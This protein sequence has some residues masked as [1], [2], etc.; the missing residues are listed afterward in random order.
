M[1]TKK[2]TVI[3]GCLW[4]LLSA[5]N[6]VGRQ[7]NEAISGEVSQIAKVIEKASK[8]F[9]YELIRGYRPSDEWEAEGRK[10]LLDSHAYYTL[11]GK[12]SDDS[13]LSMTGRIGVTV[14]LF[15][16]ADI[17]RR[18]IAQRKEHHQGNMFFEFTRSN[19]DGF[20]LEEF[21][22]FYAAVIS[23]SKVILFEDR[24]GEQREVIKSVADTLAKEPR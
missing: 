12:D 4:L 21:N 11:F 3:V 2:H 9:G 5:G 15:K 19:E 17:A 14:L 16:D 8:P 18:H 6:V 24:S 7:S 22:G 20:L 13:C 23:G 1:N 10:N